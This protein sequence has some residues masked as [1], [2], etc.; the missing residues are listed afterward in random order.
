MDHTLGALGFTPI[1]NYEQL[2]QM[3]N[4]SDGWLT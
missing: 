4:Y 2:N 1:N 3:T